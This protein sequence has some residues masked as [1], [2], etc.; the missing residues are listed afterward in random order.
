MLREDVRMEDSKREYSEIEIEVAKKLIERGYEWIA[1]DKDDA[2]FAYDGKPEKLE[3][4]WRSDKW[5]EFA[6]FVPI[7]PQI[8]WDDEEPVR[9]RDIVP[10]KQNLTKEPIGRM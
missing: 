6:S 4:Y 10:Q 7:F 3:S 5:Q 9:L 8:K 2:L 1:R